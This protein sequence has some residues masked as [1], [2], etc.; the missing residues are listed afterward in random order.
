[1]KLELNMQYAL[2]NISLFLENFK[3]RCITGNKFIT[4][5][6]RVLDVNEIFMEDAVGL[7]YFLK[8]FPISIA[9][10]SFNNRF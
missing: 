6:E 2:C 5:Y 9:L 8:K 4:Q 7:Y 3:S 1:M 10:K